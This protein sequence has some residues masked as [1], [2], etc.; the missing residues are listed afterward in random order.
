MKKKLFVLALVAL[1][2][3]STAV[4]GGIGWYWKTQ[5]LMPLEKQ[6]RGVSGT[7]W[8]SRTQGWLCQPPEPPG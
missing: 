7:F 8:A 5:L 3:L 2:L 6:G 1:L 4:V